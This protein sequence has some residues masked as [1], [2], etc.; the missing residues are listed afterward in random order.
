MA[1]KN[2]VPVLVRDLARSR[3]ARTSGAASR[4]GRPGRNRR[5]HRRHA[6]RRERA[7][8]HQRRQGQAAR[9]AA[10]LPAGVA[11]VS[12][13]DRSG[14]I[15]DRSRRCGATLIEEAVVVSLVIIAVS[16][17][18]AIGADPDPDAADRRAR[19]VH[20]DVLPRRHRRTSC[21]SAGSRWRSACSW[22]P[23]IVMVENA[24]RHYSE[25]ERRRRSAAAERYGGSMGAAR[26]VGRAIFFSLAIILVSFLPVFLLEAQEGR[27]FRPLAWTKTFADGGL[28]GS[29]GDA[30]ARADADLHSRPDAAGVRNPVSRRLRSDLFAR[31]AAVPEVS[32]D[33]GGRERRVFPLTVPLSFRIGSEFMPPLYEGSSLYMPTALPG[34]P[35]RRPLAASGAGPDH[36]V[37]PGSRE[38]FRHGRPRRQRDRQRADGDGRTR[39][40]CS[41]RGPVAPGHDV[42][43][44]AGRDGREAAV[45]G[46]PNTWT[47]RW[48]TGSTCSSPASRR[49][50]ASRSWGRISAGSRSSARQSSVACGGARRAARSRSGSPT[51]SYRH[52]GRSRGRRALRPDR[53]GRAGHDRVRH[54]RRERRRE[55]RGPRALPGERALRPRFPRRSARA[56]AVLVRSPARRAG[57]ARA[58]GAAFALAGAGDDPRRRRAAHRLRLSRPPY[59]RQRRLRRRARQVA[60]PS[61]STLPAWLHAALDRPVQVPGARARAAHGAA[62]DRVLRASSCCCT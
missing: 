19:G 22:T 36:Q 8:C 59:A 37:V 13:Y 60:A 33:D 9:V 21:R 38:R 48:G 54:R 34:C 20:P 14:L 3:S 50:W 61:R 17:P 47:S 41:S 57:A 52:R 55:R 58:A 12:A 62:A 24:Y 16:V 6:R 31:A 45:P 15:D 25:P 10:S 44:A 27:M 56:R 39:P 35:S 29:G 46:L 18:L 32:K 51:A 30:R 2:G 26:Q 43:D 42:R 28:V 40:S 7:R 11:M 23:S 1:G 49:R 4:T 53:R 5:R